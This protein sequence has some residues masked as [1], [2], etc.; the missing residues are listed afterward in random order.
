MDVGI[1]GIYVCLFLS[2]YFEVF[3]LISFIEKRPSKKTLL[4]PLSYPTVTIL[5]PCWNKAKTLGGTVNSLLE[6]DYPKNKLSI[7]IIN[8][9]STDNTLEAAEV[10]A[11]EPQV[12][13]LSKQ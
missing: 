11:H 3:L 2:L 4:K 1:L 10:F 13:I 12:R 7:L 8:D 9:G 6:L 5:V